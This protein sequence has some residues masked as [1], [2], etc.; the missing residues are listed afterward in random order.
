M[1]AGALVA[2]IGSWPL[3]VFLAHVTN[4][5]N[6]TQESLGTGLP[7]TGTAAIG[8]SFGIIAHIRI[9]RSSGKLKGSGIAMTA[10]VVGACV[11]A[12]FFVSLLQESRFWRL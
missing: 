7:P 5:S 10:I 12:L 3:G 9:K 1:A 8:V 6:F 2:S 11:F 4:F